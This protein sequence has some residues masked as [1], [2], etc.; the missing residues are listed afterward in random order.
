MSDIL[1]GDP[2]ES[3]K[4]HYQYIN[5]RFKL[6]TDYI[7]DDIHSGMDI[8]DIGQ[9]NPFTLFM[10]KEL[11]VTIKNTEGDLDVSFSI[12]PKKYD[13]VIYSHTIEHQFN[14]LYTLLE[15]KKNMKHD[16][17][18]YIIIPQRPKFLWTKHHF[19]EIDNHRMNLLIKKAGFK[20]LDKKSFMVRRSLGFHLSGIRPF[21][22]LFLHKQTIYKIK[23][24]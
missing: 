12:P 23:N 24:V 19:H 11:N 17:L 13:I 16:A 2:W 22:R 15:I 5:K 20:I 1:K 21:L 14:P 10:Q 18:M 7:K 8:L 4:K 6:I 3:Y 9:Q